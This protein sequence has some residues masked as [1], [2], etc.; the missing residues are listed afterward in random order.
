MFGIYKSSS[1]TIN[2]TTTAILAP[3]T[4]SQSSTSLPSTIQASVSTP[5]GL[6]K[7][8]HFVFIMQENRS[9]DSYFGT[10]PGADGIP[11]EYL[12]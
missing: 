9:F 1:T 7:I 12:L 6:D 8:K 10:Y 2:Q 3:T 11:K 5:Q 4:E